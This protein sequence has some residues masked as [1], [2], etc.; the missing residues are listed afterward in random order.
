[1]RK[2][3]L[4]SLIKEEI[5]SYINESRDDVVYVDNDELWF[6]YGPDSGTVYQLR[7]GR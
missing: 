5:Q 3:E 1:M 4:I 2:S 6:A 7:G